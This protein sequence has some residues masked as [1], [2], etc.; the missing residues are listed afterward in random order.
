[1]PSIMEVEEP[2]SEEKEQEKQQHLIN[3]PI[4]L[5]PTQRQSKA[6][7]MNDMWIGSKQNHVKVASRKDITKLINAQA[8]N[9]RQ[10]LLTIPKK[11]QHAKL[12]VCAKIHS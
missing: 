9:D 8:E 2:P 7:K 6:R 5:P 3:Q 1:M 10:A 12:Q 11:E 4:P